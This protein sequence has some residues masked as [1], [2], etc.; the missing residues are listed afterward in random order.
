[1]RWIDI[2]YSSMPEDMSGK[3]PHGMLEKMPETIGYEKAD[4]ENQI[5]SEN[6]AD[7]TSNKLPNRIPERLQIKC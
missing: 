3:M 6:I 5:M 7:S 4:I 1:M 2:R